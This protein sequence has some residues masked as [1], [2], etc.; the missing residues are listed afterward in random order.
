MLMPRSSWDAGGE[1]SVLLMSLHLRQDGEQ[2]QGWPRCSLSV[3]SPGSMDCIDSPGSMPR[4]GASW[5]VQD[6][7]GQLLCLVSDGNVLIFPP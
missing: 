2:C 4:L 5:I 6:W 1:S 7:C 3:D